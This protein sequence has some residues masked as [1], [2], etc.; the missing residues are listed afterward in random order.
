MSCKYFTEVDRQHITMKVM[1][2]YLHSVTV[3]LAFLAAYLPGPCSCSITAEVNE[4]NCP[5]P[6]ED[7]ECSRGMPSSTHYVQVHSKKFNTKFLCDTRTDGGGWIVFMR[8]VYRDTSFNQSWSIYKDGFG[9]VCTDYWLGNK[10]INLITEEAKYEM[11]VDIAYEKKEYYAYYKK[12]EVGDEASNY[13][14]H[15]DGYTGDADD[16]LAYHD[17]MK[18]STPDRDNDGWEGH[19]AQIYRAGWWFNACF[20]GFL[21]GDVNRVKTRPS[22]IHWYTVTGGGNILDMVE[23]KVRQ[24]KP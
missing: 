3:L 13:T 2:K 4:T 18:F 16:M 11:R 19:C 20:R 14:L 6:L 9:S 21:T 5:K 22:G 1:I 24:R 10:Y 12:F 23:M 8:R 7:T 17:R 15:I